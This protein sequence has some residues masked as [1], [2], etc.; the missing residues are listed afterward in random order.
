[1]KL[2]NSI[3][4]INHFLMI[5]NHVKLSNERNKQKQQQKDDEKKMFV[6]VDHFSFN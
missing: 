4:S 2:S 6:L 3:K 5:E 1:M